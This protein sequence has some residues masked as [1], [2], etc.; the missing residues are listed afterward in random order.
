[1]LDRAGANHLED[2]GTEMPAL[3]GPSLFGPER[4]IST[5]YRV[6]LADSYLQCRLRSIYA[7]ANAGTK[8]VGSNHF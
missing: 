1:M 3:A 8:V 7:E 2:D 5:K 6:V 4:S